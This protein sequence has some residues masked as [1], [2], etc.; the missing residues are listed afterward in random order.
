MELL[1]PGDYE[2]FDEK[3]A[4]FLD[5][6]REIFIRS[7]VTSMLRSGDLIVGLYTANGDLANASAGTYLHCVTA[8][9]PVKYIMQEFYADPTVGVREGDI[10]Y[11]NEARYG[12][13]HNCDQMAMMP[14]F[15]DGELI[16]WTCALAHQ[17]ETG[18]VEPGGMPL[19]ARSRNDEGMKLTPIK[20]GENFQIRADMLRMMENFIGRA[21]RM[22]AVDT[23]ARVT[24]ADRLRV[25][26]VELAQEK[27][28]DF[29]RGLLRRLVVEAEQAARQADL[30]LERRRLPLDDFHRHDRPRAGA[31]ARRA[32]GHQARRLDH[33]GLHRQL[34]GERFAVQLL[35]AHRRRPRRD[36]HLR[37]PVRRPA[38]IERHARGLRVACAA[39]G[40]LFN[41]G[42]D[43]AISNSPTVN[44]LVM[45]L[46]PQVFARMMFDI[47]DR[48]Q[49]GA[50]NSNNGSADHLRGPQPIRHSRRRARGDDAQ[51]RG[52]GRAHRHGRRACVRI[53]VVPRGPLARRRGHRDR[54]PVPAPVLQFAR[55]QR[56]L[57]EV[58][59]RRGNGDGTRA[60]P[61]AVFLLAGPRQELGDQLRGG[62][63]RRLSVER[64]PGHLGAQHRPLR[65]D[66]P[67][68]RGPSEQRRRAGDRARRS[69]A[70]TSSRTSIGRR[71]SA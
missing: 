11:A 70:T 60:V 57:R 52:P 41:A 19:S 20:I 14:V 25:R 8:T 71:A 67:R 61:R 27:G 2:I 50:P 16:A 26:I 38:G 62:A 49:I 46:T 44:S 32:D 51:H 34:A 56:R 13:I 42:A 15:H 6:A 9:L 4:N 1:K 65:E 3:I 40:C 5:E 22:Q 45:S 43:A 63:I 55:G 64:V 18:A 54:V 59:G 10:F 66:E 58:P 47:P 48:M 12:G 37:L 21:P 31:R 29:V 17:P 7:G 39:E 35:P 33:H 28:N 53:P 23:R 36:L 69:A 68:R 24:G 30:D